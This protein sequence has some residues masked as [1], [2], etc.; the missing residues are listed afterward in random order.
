MV[1]SQEKDFAA[2]A[3]NISMVTTNRNRH[4]AG[5]T[6]KSER[7]VGQLVPCF[8]RAYDQDSGICNWL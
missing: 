3:S 2:G 5:S 8:H 7:L 4:M 1:L 6:L